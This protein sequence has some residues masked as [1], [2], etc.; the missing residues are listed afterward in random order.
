MSANTFTTAGAFLVS[1]PT[2]RVAGETPLIEF[3]VV[4]NA[5]NEK[6]Y[7]PKFITVSVAADSAMGRTA[8]LLKAKEAVTVS[9]RLD[10]RTYQDK[11]G[12]TKL[13][14]AIDRPSMLVPAADMRERRAAAGAEAPAEEAAPAE[15]PKKNA[16]DA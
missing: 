14:F 4:D 8:R 5:W 11:S 3:T 6:R 7:L 12:N 1:D 2:E 16:W 10:V 9:G 15:A 13:A